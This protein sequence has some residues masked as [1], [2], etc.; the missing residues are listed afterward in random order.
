M[1]TYSVW[2]EEVDGDIPLVADLVE[3]SGQ[4]AAVFAGVLVC[5]HRFVE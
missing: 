4:A 3:P 1:E 2:R 5:T